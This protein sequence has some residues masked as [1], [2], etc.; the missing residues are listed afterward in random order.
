[1]IVTHTMWES[2]YSNTILELVYFK[3]CFPG[4]SVGIATGYGFDGPGIESIYPTWND[5]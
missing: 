4:S 5:V 2:R 1:M 3:K